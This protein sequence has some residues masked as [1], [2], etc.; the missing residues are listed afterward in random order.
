[1]SL[2]SHDFF[3]YL[4]QMARGA[5]VT[6][7]LFI[8]GFGSAL[9]VGFLVG[10]ASLASN[11]LVQAAWRIYSS[12]MMGVPSLV[13]LFI[14]YY[15][16]DA[17]LTATLGGR[18]AIDITPFMAGVITL[19]AVYAAYIAELL[20]GAFI[21]LPKG[22]YEA[23]SALGIR[24]FDAWLYVILPQIIRL[25]FP[26]LVNIWLIV[27]KDTPLVSLA[28]LH[29]LVAMSKIAAGSTK[30]PFIFFVAAALF[31]I[32][33]SAL[34]SWLARRIEIRLDRGLRRA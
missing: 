1:V 32:G 27:L 23:C 2:S 22:Q 8:V 33:F 17:V 29:D 28:G 7:E 34:T 16:G 25:A 20:R 19:T 31:F 21:N 6:A 12:A 26:G 9:L 18:R 24:R 15:G 4:E 14:I 11:K 13:V 30:S 10:I 5:L 3:G